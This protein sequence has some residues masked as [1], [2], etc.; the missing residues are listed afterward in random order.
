MAGHGLPIAEISS[1]RKHGLIVFSLCCQ[2]HPRILDIG[3]GSAEPIGRYVIESGCDI[4]GVD[5][6][7]ELIAISKEHFPSETWHMARTYGTTIEKPAA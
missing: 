6:S 5:S 2:A 3:C 7:P 4:T 1:S